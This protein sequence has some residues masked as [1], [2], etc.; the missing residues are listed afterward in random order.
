MFNLYTIFD[1]VAKRYSPPFIS[2]NHGTA[3]RQFRQFL[4]TQPEAVRDDYRLNS[5]GTWDDSTGILVA[6]EYP[7]IVDEFEKIPVKEL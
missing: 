4:E 1:T 3:D 7:V 2:T 5:L 6:N